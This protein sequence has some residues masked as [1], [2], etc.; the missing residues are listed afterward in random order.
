[1]GSQGRI[2]RPDPKEADM[3]YPP[4][5][6]LRPPDPAGKIYNSLDDMASG[7][8]DLQY[9]EM[10][11]NVGVGKANRFNGSINWFLKPALSATVL[12]VAQAK[13]SEAKSECDEN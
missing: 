2:R 5:A 10:F 7:R 11:C 6:R 1:M 4:I 9:F 13:Q 8:H 12:P 3:K